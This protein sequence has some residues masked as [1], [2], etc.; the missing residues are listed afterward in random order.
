MISKKDSILISS[1]IIG[2]L[3]RNEVMK[4][5]VEIE[6]LNEA[7]TKPDMANNSKESQLARLYYRNGK[8]LSDSSLY[9]WLLDLP[10]KSGGASPCVLEPRREA[11]VCDQTL[12]WRRPI[13]EECQS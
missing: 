8:Y 12:S 9:R 5:S 1:L 11:M 2:K 6:A 7:L 4:D 13:G 10:Q 3:T